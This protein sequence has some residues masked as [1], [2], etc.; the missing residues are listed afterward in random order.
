MKNKSFFYP[1]LIVCLISC[2]NYYNETIQWADDINKGTDIETVKKSQPSF[3][4][5]SWEK[6]LVIEDEK[7][8]EI[9]IVNNYDALSMSNFLVFIDNKYQGRESKK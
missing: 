6:P 9:E 3:V 8:Y 7:L 2:K 4:K 5:I 1:L